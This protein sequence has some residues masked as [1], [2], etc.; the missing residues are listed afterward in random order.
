MHQVRI[1]EGVE[2]THDELISDLD[3]YIA[4]A[5]IS[6]PATAK[7]VK[8]LRAAVKLHKPADS[9]GGVTC[10]YCYDLAWEPSGLS[11]DDEDFVYPC[12]TIRA[13]EKELK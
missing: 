8:A 7:L 10:I 2:M 4:V 12:P 11:M 5:E 13:I 1:Q 6:M 9:W 3:R